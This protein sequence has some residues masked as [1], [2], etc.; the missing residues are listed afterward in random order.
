MQGRLIRQAS[1]RRCITQASWPPRVKSPVAPA[2][3]PGEDRETLSVFAMLPKGSLSQ[4]CSLSSIPLLMLVQ[5]LL[6]VCCKG[7]Q[8]AMPSRATRDQWRRCR[9]AWTGEFRLVPPNFC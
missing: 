9:E 5:T 3:V 1:P 8:K 2:S 4:E 6:P 7:P